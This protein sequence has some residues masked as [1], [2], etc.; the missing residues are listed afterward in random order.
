ME[1][2]SFQSPH[3][4]VGKLPINATLKLDGTALYICTSGS[5]VSEGRFAIEIYKCRLAEKPPSIKRKINEC[6]RQY[7]Q[8]SG[9]HLWEVFRRRNV[10]MGIDV[11]WVSRGR[12]DVVG[13]VKIWVGY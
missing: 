11:R 9:L 7:H 10:V 6:I 4:F 13:F 5:I 3:F 1:K 12:R 2:I 8:I